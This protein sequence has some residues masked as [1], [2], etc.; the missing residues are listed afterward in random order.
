M[1][2]RSFLTASNVETIYPSFAD[3]KYEPEQQTIANDVERL[4]LL[5]LA[6][7]REDDLKHATFE[8]QD[9][10]VNAFAPLCTKEKSLAQLD[11]AGPYLD[12][13]LPELGGLKEY[14]ALFREAVAAVPQKFISIEL[15]EIAGLYPEEHRFEEFLTLALR[16]FDRPEGIHF[17]CE[18]V[19]MTFGNITIEGT[20]GEPLDDDD[21]LAELNA[22]EGLED[23]EPF[24]IEGFTANSHAEVLTRISGL[25]MESPLPSA[26]M[27]LDDLEYSGDEQWNFTC[28][29]GAGQHGSMGIGREVPWEKEDANFGWEFNMEGDD[30][31]EFEEDEEDEEDED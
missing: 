14:V 17:E 31:F 7:F 20:D 9:Q 2:N 8:V 24:T 21:P 18:D 15:E 28:I 16:G 1:S 23:S 22:F 4:P 27:Y 26:R 30:D 13:I 12:S 6:L 29:L 10:T 11:A 3:K 19:E 5:W 25:R